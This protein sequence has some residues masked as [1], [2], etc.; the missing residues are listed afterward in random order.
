VNSGF[1]DSHDVFCPDGESVVGGGVHRSQSSGMTFSVNQSYPFDDD[2]DAD[3]IP[4]NGW[5]VDVNNTGPVSVF[6]ILY[7]VCTSATS[8]TGAQE[9]APL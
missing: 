5:T 7:A 9:G 3:N 1:Q 8:V 2:S 6:Y 4:N